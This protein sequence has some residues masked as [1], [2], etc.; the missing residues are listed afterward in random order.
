MLNEFDDNSYNDTSI[1]TTSPLI[2]SLCHLRS[3]IVVETAGG[4]GEGTLS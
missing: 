2:Q 4:L 3:A 1:L